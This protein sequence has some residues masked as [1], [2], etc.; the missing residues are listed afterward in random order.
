MQYGIQRTDKHIGT[1]YVDIMMIDG[2][3]GVSFIGSDAIR[4]QCNVLN[5]RRGASTHS[6]RFT[7]LN[8]AAGFCDWCNRK[9]APNNPGIRYEVVEYNE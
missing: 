7:D 3:S 9:Y 1:D 4:P 5:G 2:K 8:I 6:I